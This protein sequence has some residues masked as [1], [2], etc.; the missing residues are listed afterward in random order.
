MIIQVFIIHL[1]LIVCVVATLA[2]SDS[3]VLEGP[4]HALVVKFDPSSVVES[5][6]KL[7]VLRLRFARLSHSKE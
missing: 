2:R 1:A 7:T 5:I 3:H 4:N 6:Q